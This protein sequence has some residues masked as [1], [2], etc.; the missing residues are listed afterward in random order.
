MKK[1]LNLNHEKADAWIGNI[2]ML[3][4]KPGVSL[5]Y[6]NVA[7]QTMCISMILKTDIK[8]IDQNFKAKKKK[9]T[10]HTFHKPKPCNF[11]KVLNWD[12]RGRNMK[13][14]KQWKRKKTRKEEMPR[15]KRVSNKIISDEL[16][17]VRKK[18]DWNVG[19]GRWCEEWREIANCADFQT[20]TNDWPLKPL[21]NP[22]LIYD[23]TQVRRF[24]FS[25]I[26]VPKLCQRHVQIKAFNLKSKA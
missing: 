8:V 3:P 19:R 11:A 10:W 6:Y 13:H 4:F 23:R 18:C 20:V 5:A 17:I 22:I 2:T 24:E 25:C 14:S 16:I 7:V 21:L 9:L 1:L 15:M 26:A 12:R